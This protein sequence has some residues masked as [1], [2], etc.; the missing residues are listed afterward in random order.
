MFSQMAPTGSPTGWH[1]GLQKL[2]GGLLGAEIDDPI[3]HSITP[4]PPLETP[5]EPV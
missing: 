4:P 3:S 1:L 5:P 2:L